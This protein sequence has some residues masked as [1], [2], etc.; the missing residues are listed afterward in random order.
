MDRFEA[1]IALGLPPSAT[2]AQIKEAYRDLA[3]VWHPDRFAG[4]PR[5]RAKAEENLKVVNEAYEVLRTGASHEPRRASDS[6]RDRGPAPTPQ[7]DTRK[8]SEPEKPS[9][10]VPTRRAKNTGA[11]GYVLGACLFGV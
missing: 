8:Q 3:K 10:P 5:L 2:P 11:L 1:L 6:S 9:E 7:A 4:E